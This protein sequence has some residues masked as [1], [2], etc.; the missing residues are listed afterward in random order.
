[1][2]LVAAR[3]RPA[4]TVHLLATGGTIAE[5]KSRSLGAADLVELAPEIADLAEMTVEDFS[6]I[7]SDRMT[8]ERQFRLAARIRELIESRPDLSGIVVT[9]GTDS[10]EES[11]F[12]VDLLVPAGPPVVFTA[13]MRPPRVE[14]SDGPRNLVNAVRLAASPGLRGLGVLVTLND[15]IHAAREVQKTDAI[16]LNAFA[17]PRSGPLG[18]IDGERVYLFQRPARRLELDVAAVEPRVDLVKLAAGSDGRAI[19]SAVTEG[20]RGLV[21]EAFGRGHAPPDV[22]AAVRFARKRDVIVIFTTRTGGG[23]V[24]LSEEARSLGVLSGE[25]LDGLK[26][27]LVLVAAL[28]AT[29]NLETLQSYFATLSGELV[30]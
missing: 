21:I 25:D 8:P 6:H 20:A 30:P 10:L 28:A 17:S 7:G 18:R 24:E 5:G 3:A 15:E 12:L 1:V 14:D 13:A 26:A 29:T 2:L 16:A 19:R 27:R 22:M 9:H 4:P 11:A 23:R